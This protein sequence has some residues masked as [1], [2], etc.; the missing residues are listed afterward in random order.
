ML[1][2]LVLLAGTLLFIINLSGREELTNPTPSGQAGAT[3]VLSK[4][5]TEQLANYKTLL[6]AST[7]NPNDAAAGQA[8]ASAK[9]K[10]DSM[11]VEDQ[12]GVGALQ[13]Y[14]RTQLTQN[15][16]LG[17]DVTKLRER[18]SSYSTTLPT[19]KDTLNKSEVNTADRVQ[20]TSI[21]IA[22]SVAICVIGL[23]AVFVGG[24]Y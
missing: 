12:Q 16:G 19:L 3:I 9:T 10:L 7:L 2:W 11:L 24:V 13:Q 14:I 8:T 22:K 18:V 23:F 4:D 17:N 21:L 15:S 20:D 6:T 1:E 5:V